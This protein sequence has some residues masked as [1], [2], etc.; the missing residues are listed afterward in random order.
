MLSGLHKKYGPISFGIC[1]RLM[2]FNGV[3]ELLMHQGLFSDVHFMSEQPIEKEFIVIDDSG[4]DFGNT[5]E[6]LVS[7]R[8]Y[9]FT[10]NNCNLHFDLDTDF[11]LQVPWHSDL[12]GFDKIVIGDRWSP[13]DAP[14]VDD[15][16]LSNL[17][18][19]YDKFNGDRFHYLDY[20]NGLL[21]N[22]SYIKH[23]AYPLLTTFTGIGILADLMKKETKVLWDDDMRMWNGKPVEDDFRLHYFTNRNSSLHYIK[24][25]KI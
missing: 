16:R 20:S 25:F 6:S 4:S 21:Y 18:K 17:I 8:F 12:N 11:E 10:R 23:S 15:R 19:A 13:K 3:K 9:N 14:D 22:L 7:R 2:R 1:D 24:D 5:G